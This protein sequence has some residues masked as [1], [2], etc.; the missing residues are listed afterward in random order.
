MSKQ[1]YQLKKANF[2]RPR[3]WESVGK[4]TDDEQGLIA[5]AQQLNRLSDTYMYKVVKA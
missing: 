5:R 1:K 4:P 3:Y 2:V